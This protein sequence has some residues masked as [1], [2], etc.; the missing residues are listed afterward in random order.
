[1]LTLPLRAYCV[2]GVI[3]RMYTGSTQS[4][5]A[6]VFY[7]LRLPV[8]LQAATAALAHSVARETRGRPVPAET[9]HLTLVFVGD[10]DARVLPV[11][12]GIGASIAE[13]RARDAIETAGVQRINLDRLGAF[14]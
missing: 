4:P 9:L 12:E 14:P 13:A 10:V 6:R 3:R 8:A 7:A 5:R 11:L 1:M 2:R